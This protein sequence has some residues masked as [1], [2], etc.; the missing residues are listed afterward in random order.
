[1]RPTEDRPQRSGCCQAGAPALPQR[2]SYLALAWAAI[3]SA[4]YRIIVQ[5]GTHQ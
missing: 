1:M 5:V 4:Q 2:V 3:E